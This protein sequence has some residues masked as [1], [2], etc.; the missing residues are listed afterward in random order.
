VLL[1]RLPLDQ[2]ALC[3]VASNTTTYEVE[4]LKRLSVHNF[5]MA[6]VAV[7]LFATMAMAYAALNYVSGPGP[8]NLPVTI[9][10]LVGWLPIWFIAARIIRL[11]EP[12]AA[13]SGRTM[14]PQALAACCIV[15]TPILLLAAIATYHQ[16]VSVT[17]LALCAAAAAAC[18]IGA[19]SLLQYFLKA[20][21]A[22]GYCLDRALVAAGSM[23]T[24]LALAAEL[25][26]R[27]AGRLRV[28]AAVP[29]P[30]LPD[31]P[32]F[33]WVEQAARRKDVDRVLLAG[34]PATSLAAET[35]LRQLRQCP[36]NVSLIPDLATPEFTWQFSAAGGELT[37][38]DGTDQPLSTAQAAYKRVIDI[39]VALSA[40]VVT[41]PALFA[42]AL[43]IKLDSR[44]PALFRQRRAGLHGATFSMWKFRTMYHHMAD[45]SSTTQTCRDDNRVTGV[46]RFLRKTSLDELPQAINV[47]FGD[48][49]IVGPRPHALGMTIAGHEVSELI[50]NYCERYR[51]KPGITGWAQVN[52]CRGE[53]DTVRKLRRRVAL[54]CY[55]IDNWSV[56]MDVLIMART[57]A[58]LLVDRHAY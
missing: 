57:L 21:V 54:D 18:I 49:S 23:A 43:A 6:L 11:Y 26:L 3:S 1:H 41:A 56:K 27:T 46:G 22:R 24:A 47:L 25:E 13:G 51:V 4:S 14:I 10:L 9:A 5:I 53:L 50:A 17:P 34:G 35:F 2:S 31:S 36:V 39:A 32:S 44:G 30:G 55:Y 19:R 38:I 52:G 29:I 40:L 45:E 12:G 33:G 20:A 37:I 58:L 48:M 7:D 28:A 42:I 15:F 16:A 8:S